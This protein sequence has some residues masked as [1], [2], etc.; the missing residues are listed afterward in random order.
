MAAN[1]S[2]P[3]K[4]QKDTRA[5]LLSSVKGV[6]LRRFCKD[7]HALVHEPFPWKSLGFGSPVE[8]LRAMPDSVRFEFCEKDGEYRLYGIGNGHCYMPSW[9]IKAQG[10]HRGYTVH[11][12]KL[13][14]SVHVRLCVSRSQS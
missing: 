13:Y 14:V 4:V 9:F 12:Y 1:S 11:T 5:V 3:Q 2:I 10:G 6:A 7:Y 8:L